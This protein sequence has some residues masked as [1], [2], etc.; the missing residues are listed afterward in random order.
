M[1]HFSKREQYNNYK[2][3]MQSNGN[4]VASFRE[5]FNTTNNT[6]V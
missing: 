3:W 6:R 2:S 5:W 4:P 1:T